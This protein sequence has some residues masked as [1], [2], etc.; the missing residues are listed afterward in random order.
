MLLNGVTIT[1]IDCHTS[2]TEIIGLAKRYP[3]AEFGL[4]VSESAAGKKMRY[5]DF[6]L[7]KF[8]QKLFVKHDVNYAIHVCG[9]LSKDLLA[10]NGRVFDM[11]ER[12]VGRVQINANM[13]YIK[14]VDVGAL[15]LSLNKYLAGHQVIVQQNN[16]ESLQ[17]FKLLDEEMKSLGTR[18]GIASLTSGPEV[19]AL[20]DASGG[21]GV[22]SDKFPAPYS[23]TYCGYAGGLCP[24]NVEDAILKLKAMEPAGKHF[25]ID[26][27]SGVRTDDILDLNKVEEVLETASK[28][29]QE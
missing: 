27:E 20:F 3:F 18:G 9:K 11:L 19:V 24:E 5:M 21:R 26:M 23:K 17:F 4:L 14:K 10:G 28:L 16:A 8:A 7:V 1:G 15:A 6:E 2:L 29:L 12:V 13:K 25:Y 22:E